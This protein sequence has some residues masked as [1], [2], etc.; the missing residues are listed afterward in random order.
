MFSK[1]L[2]YF[3]DISDDKYQESLDELRK[4]EKFF[5]HHY[6]N[7]DGYKIFKNISL[8]IKPFRYG[9]RISEF[10]AIND[11]F[12]CHSNILG[13]LADGEVV[14]CCLAYESSIS[15]GRIDKLD[16][17]TVLEDGKIFLKNLRTK[18]GKA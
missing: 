11:N 3:Y 14:P 6:I 18:S 15:M 12:S 17:K 1:F 13:I 2:N 7:Q 10:Y 16:L 5:S 9:R 4:P 8:K